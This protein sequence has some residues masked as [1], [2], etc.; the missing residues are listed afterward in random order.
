METDP[1]HD[2]NSSVWALR[3]RWIL[4]GDRP[5]LENAVLTISGS[6]ISAV[7]EN[8]SGRRPIDFGSAVILPGL[9]NSH[10]H[11][12]FGQL[13]SPV[14]APGQSFADWLRE[15]V[16]RRRSDASL[17]AADELQR[18]R[19]EGTVRSLDE[20]ARS[21]ATSIA[22]IARPDWPPETVAGGPGCL[23]FLELLGQSA[24]RVDPLMRLAQAHLD[25]ADCPPD[26]GS[27]SA[28]SGRG[29]KA[30]LSP[31]APYTVHPDLL[32][33][34]CRLSRER[35]APVA[36]HLAESWDEL[37]LLRSH[38]G[39]LVELLREL[40]AWDPTILPR[41][42]RPRDYLEQ[43]AAA[44]RALV[45]HGNFLDVGDWAFLAD[46][47]DQMSVVYCP[48]THAFF[49]STPYPLAEMLARGVRVVLGT[50]SRATNP[51]LDFLAELR[52]VARHHPAVAPADILKMATCDSAAAL[53]CA[54]LGRLTPPA[55]ADLTV[56]AAGGDER[57]PWSWLTDPRGG[58]VEVVRRGRRRPGVEANS[59]D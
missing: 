38:C 31:H 52:W 18:E 40:G 49:L 41:G 35:N 34:V 24:E 48:R 5:P 54:D 20:L 37:E 13:S 6:T 30:G 51:D 16:T 12:E 11:L 19:R 55:H 47:R 23:V 43:L 17:R 58:V 42:L 27:S 32:T 7:G 50:D 26:R 28:W 22:E 10:T 1:R 45:V 8:Q 14:G 46:R 3:A 9:I 56:L 33:R 57:D 29:W 15:I 2:D 21:G 36:M 53:G 4:P 44:S 59:D 25:A 39:P